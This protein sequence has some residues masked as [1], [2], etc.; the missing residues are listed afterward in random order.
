MTYQQLK[1]KQEELYKCKE[2]K[3]II[4]VKN[5]TYFPYLVKQLIK[6]KLCFTCDFWIEK[7]KEVNNPKS[8]RINKWHYFIGDE[9]KKG[10]FRGFDGRRFKIKFNNDKKIE[11]TNLWTQ[12]EIPKRFRERLFDNAIFI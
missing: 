2:C 1:K 10:G 3:K 6:E 4:K 12:G 5:L 7:I 11:T 8:V 9:N